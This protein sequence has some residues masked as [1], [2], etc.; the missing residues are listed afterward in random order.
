MQNCK[1]RRVVAFMLTIFLATASLGGCGSNSENKKTD[2]KIQIKVQYNCGRMNLN[3]ESVL[4]DKF[5]NVDIVTD[6]ITGDSD[7]IIAREMEHDMEPDIYLYEG[8]EWDRTTDP[9]YNT[10]KMALPDYRGYYIRG[11]KSANTSNKTLRI[12]EHEKSAAPN[13][14]GI[15]GIGW[16]NKYENDTNR[17]GKTQITGA[18]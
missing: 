14:K 18:Y 16:T 13:I 1:L 2:E 12:G 8:T 5:P 9:S 10:N 11:W 15:G 17:I 4:E 7:Y 3:L 6:E